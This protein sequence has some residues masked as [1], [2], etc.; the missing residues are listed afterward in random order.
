MC[1]HCELSTTLN[2]KL[3]HTE[4]LTRILHY[5]NSTKDEKYTCNWNLI[6]IYNL[7]LFTLFFFLNFWFLGGV[8]KTKLVLLLFLNKAKTEQ[9]ESLLFLLDCFLLEEGRGDYNLSHKVRGIHIT[10]TASY[11]KVSPNPI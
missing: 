9:C 7:L 6:F 10:K 4:L 11:Q 2:I 1:Y 3:P 5:Y 8:E